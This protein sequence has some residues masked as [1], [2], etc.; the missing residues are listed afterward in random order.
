MKCSL[1]VTFEGGEG[2]I[3]PGER[4]RG[5]CLGTGGERERG[6][7][8]GTGGEEDHHRPKHQ[9]ATIQQL[10]ATMCRLSYIIQ[11]KYVGSFVGVNGASL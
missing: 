2:G 4:E 1:N 7:C 10:I 8:L 5:E 9:Y 3:C 11:V 6:E